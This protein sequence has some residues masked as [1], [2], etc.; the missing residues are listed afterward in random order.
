MVVAPP[1]SRGRPDW[2]TF[3]RALMIPKVR[4]Q[5]NDADLAWLLGDN[6]ENMERARIESPAD[7]AELD[8]A[9]EEAWKRLRPG[10]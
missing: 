4:Q 8:A 3:A 2:R 6:A 9:I 7:M 1:L 10:Q 5:T